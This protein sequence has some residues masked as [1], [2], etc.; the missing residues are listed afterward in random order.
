MTR[1]VEW[2][3]AQGWTRLLWGYQPSD[4]DDLWQY[5]IGGEVYQVNLNGTT[6]LRNTPL[7]SYNYLLH[8]GADGTSWMLVVTGETDRPSPT[9]ATTLRARSRYSSHS[10]RKWRGLTS[11]PNSSNLREQLAMSR[12]TEE[13]P[14]G[15]LSSKVS[16]PECATSSSENWSWPMVQTRTVDVIE[17]YHGTKVADPYRWLEED[18]D[19][20]AEVGGGAKP[21]HSGIPG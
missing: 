19:E 1:V 20:T 10:F 21:L 15:R 11:P 9:S 5:H 6:T 3:V 8:V 12:P 7:D 4:G 2:D 14:W 16:S 18:N 13:T 17:D